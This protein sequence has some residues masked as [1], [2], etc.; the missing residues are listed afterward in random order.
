MPFRQYV[1]RWI[2]EPPPDQLFEISEDSLAA[3]APRD[4]SR[5]RVEALNERAL[6]P[7]PNSVNLLRPQTFRDALT[8]VAPRPGKRNAAALVIPDYAVRMAILDFEEFP[9]GEE[10]RIALIRFRLRKSVPFHI[11]DAQVSYAIQLQ[12][13]KQVEVFAVTI[14]RPILQEYET[15]FTES[16]Y[17]VGLV[18]PSSVASLPLYGA[19][20]NGLTLVAK[21]A[22]TA[23]SMLLLE[24]HRVRLIRCLDLAF[25]EADPAN[26]AD[27]HLLMLLEQTVAFAEDQLGQKVGQ[28]ALCG[29][30]PNTDAIGQAA[31]R[32]L[33]IP[34]E[35]VR[36]RFGPAAQG[37]AG[38]LGLME[39]YAA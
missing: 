20:A 11:D 23:F 12:Q 38:L 1:Q 19:V 16:G 8:R 22:G 2:T 32:E 24:H 36:S 3:A 33:Q 35:N 31:E 37:N 5:T 21:I 34:Y 9:P 10:E 39:R 28:L 29:F 4:P 14:A 25:G 15:L 30:G 13:P 18:T 7:S 6:N 26:Y 27:D 17:R